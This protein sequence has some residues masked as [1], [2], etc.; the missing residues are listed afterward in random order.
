MWTPSGAVISWTPGGSWPSLRAWKT[1]HSRRL[2]RLR[3]EVAKDSGSVQW[4]NSS[5]SRYFSSTHRP[6]GRPMERH[7][8]GVLRISH[9]KA[10][11]NTKSGPTG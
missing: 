1:A 8:S 4:A 2:R 11:V 5:P 10:L 7:C 6:C 3:H 9:S